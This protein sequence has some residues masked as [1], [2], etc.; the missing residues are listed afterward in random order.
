VTESDAAEP[1]AADETIWGQVDG[2]E[3]AYVCG[4][5]VDPTGQDCEISIRTEDGT[6]VGRGSANRIRPDLAVLGL[7]RTNIAFRVAVEDLGAHAA[8]HI[9]ASDMLLSASPLLAGPGLFSGRLEILDG[10][11]VGWVTERVARFEAPD[12]TILDQEGCVVARARS[13]LCAQDHPDPNFSPAEFSAAL[14]D[15]CFGGHGLQLTAFANGVAFASATCTLP[16]TGTLEVVS[17]TRCAGWLFSP[18]APKRAL[19]L[20]IY[21]DGKRV[22]QTVAKLPRSDVTAAFPRAMAPGFDVTLPPHRQRPT[23]FST[24]AIR[25]RGGAADILDGPRIV[26]SMAAVVAGARRAAQAVNAKESVFSP[27]ERAVVSVALAGLL[28]RT[29]EQVPF[30]AQGAF[31]AVTSR[32]RLNILIP[33]YR[34]TTITA[35]CIRSVLTTRDAAQDRIVLV[36]DNSP[37]PDMAPVLE[38]FASEPGV[39]VLT[40]PTNLGFIDSCNRGL[41]FCDGGDVI[42]LNSDTELYPGGLDE[43]WQVAHS[44]PNIGTVTALSTNA[45]IFSYPHV[46]LRAAALDDILWP[47]VAALSLQANR[48]VVV[49]M[50]TGHGFCMLIKREVLDRVG[51]LDTTFGR[52][53]GEEND[54]CARAA[55]LGYRNVAAPGAFVRHRESVSFL[56]DKSEL[57]RTNLGILNSRYPEYTPTIMEAERTDPLRRARWPLDIERLR[58]ASAAGATFAVVICNWLGGGTVKAIK[59][60]EATAG[61]RSSEKITVQ[62]REDGYIEISVERPSLRAIFAP[63]EADRLFSLLSAATVAMV[64]VHQLVGYDATFCRLLAGWVRGRRAVYYAHDFYPLCQRVTMIDAGQAFCNAAETEVCERCIAIGGAHDSVRTAELS[65][66]SHRALFGKILANIG[67]VVAPSAS[68]AGYLNRIFPECPV[69]VVPHPEL[70]VT[71]PATV[72]TAASP[73]VLLLGALGPHKGSAELLAIARRAQLVAPQL[74]F[75][76]V[77]HT[78]IDEQLEK[79]GNVTVTGPYPPEDLGWMLNQCRGRLALFL[80]IWPETYSYTLTEV[81]AHGFI[82]FVPDLGAPAERVRESGFGVIFGFP[83]DPAE[84]VRVLWDFASGQRDIASSARPSN[85]VVSALPT[86]ALYARVCQPTA[87]AKEEQPLFPE[88]HPFVRLGIMATSAEVE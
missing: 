2:L 66:A 28:A 40:N 24:I 32:I 14:S 85:V 74:R 34:G 80:P 4:W 33:I 64:V 27:A 21:R 41:R 39:V 26:G 68:T 59:D 71:L 11:A 20:D 23:D 10:C 7:G 43:L 5:A 75:R 15:L 46:S 42:L 16:L 48:G 83:I 87:P 47:E 18:S 60:I 57:L 25:L 37:E 19:A 56:G 9:F 78:N 73:E 82:P 49:D 29:R 38:Y 54:F 81:V 31:G 69:N 45:T 88:T 30:V 3:G 50:P 77:G 55:D 72:R 79:L 44:A 13:S 12:I 67:H 8:L 70:G 84:V 35:E 22:A 63:A 53:Y 62:C 51:V 61:Y 76:V 65:P 36:N 52:G 1:V 58:R 86:L 17:A 6:V